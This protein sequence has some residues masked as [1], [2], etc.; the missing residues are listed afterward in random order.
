MLGAEAGISS[1]LLLPL[2]ETLPLPSFKTGNSSPGD[3]AKL[4]TG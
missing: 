2:E 3:V 4:R 1:S